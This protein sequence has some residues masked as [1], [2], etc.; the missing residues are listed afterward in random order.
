MSI[1]QDRE[2]S[3]LDSN[4]RKL[5]DKRDWPNHPAA[6][7][8]S[9]RRPVNAQLIDLLSAPCFD[10]HCEKNGKAFWPSRF[11]KFLFGKRIFFWAFYFGNILLLLKFKQN[12]LI[13]LAIRLFMPLI[14]ARSAL[15][16]RLANGRR[17]LRSDFEALPKHFQS[18]PIHARL[19]ATQDS[20][21]VYPAWHFVW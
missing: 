5:L 1:G 18:L 16:E 2:L 21:L 9:N 17:S 14:W 7:R 3:I 8:L 10:M 12:F 19:S 15:R 6:F 4:I 11:I 20:G 13:F